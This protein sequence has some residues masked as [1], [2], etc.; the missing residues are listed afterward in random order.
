MLDS[1]AGFRV[2]EAY[3]VLHVLTLLP[4]EFNQTFAVSFLNFL[5]LINK[6]NQ[7]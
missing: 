5:I 3:G 4:P 6:I 1:G 2:A 7:F